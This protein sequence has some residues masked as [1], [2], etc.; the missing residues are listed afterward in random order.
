MHEKMWKNR[1]KSKFLYIENLLIE[2][3]Y[4]IFCSLTVISQLFE[5]DFTVSTFHAIKKLGRNVC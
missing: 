5:I 1:W 3:I 2:R 4:F